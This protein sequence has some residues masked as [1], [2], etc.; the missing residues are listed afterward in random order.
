MSTLL[1]RR[2][3]VARNLQSLTLLAD[4]REAFRTDALA[5]TVPPQRV[6]ALLHAEGTA[7]VLFPG[8]VPGVPA[9]TVKVQARFSPQAS[10]ASGVL[11][12]HDLAS[13]GLLALMDSA[14]LTAVR[15]GVLGAL[16]ADVLARPDASSVALLGAGPQ[17]VLQLKSLRLVRTLRQAFVYDADP[18]LTA[19]FAARMYKELS[20]P[21]RMAG[22]VQEAVEAADIVVMS[23]GSRPATLLPEMLRPGM[24]VTVLS[25]EESGK[26]ELSP[27]LLQRALFVCDHRGQALAGGLG[28]AGVTEEA[29]HAELGEIIAGMRPG[30]TSAGQLTVFGGVGLPFQDLAAAWHVYQAAQGDEDVQRIDFGT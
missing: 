14:H 28:G 27:E 25:T 17:A 26:V 3:D 30:R 2:S 10:L 23:S 20:L 29:I 21:V 11:Q 13:G 19:A 15:D 5:R 18:V 22:S 9:Y 1:L 4:M 7:S 8:S 16:A 12:L 24:H 6:R